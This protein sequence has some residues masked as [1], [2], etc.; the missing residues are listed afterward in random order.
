VLSDGEP[1]YAFGYPLG[2]AE[3]RQHPGIMMGHIS[4]A[5][6]VTSAIVASRIEATQ[7]VHH[8]TEPGKQLVRV[9]I[10]SLYGLASNITRPGLADELA[11]RGIPVEGV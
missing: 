1:V 7:M 10:P 4:H 11:N 2:T 6:R 8:L 9:L 3:V 5:P